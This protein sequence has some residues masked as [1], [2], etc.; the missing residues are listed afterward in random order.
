MDTDPTPEPETGSHL[1]PEVEAQR[2][3]ELRE[4][5]EEV[6]KKAKEDLE[7]GGAGRTFVDSGVRA[8][9]EADGDTHHPPADR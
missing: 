7:I 8:Q 2:L 9:V 3:D 1:D 5:N 6:A 4:R